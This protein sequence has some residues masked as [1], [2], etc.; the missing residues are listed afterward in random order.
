MSQMKNLLLD[1]LN[2]IG[3]PELEEELM[4]ADHV[5]IPAGFEGEFTPQIARNF[6]KK[7]GQLLIPSVSLIQ[8]MLHEYSHNRLV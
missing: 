6:Y 4:T 2:L 3:G 8:R 7:T 1:Y 5:H